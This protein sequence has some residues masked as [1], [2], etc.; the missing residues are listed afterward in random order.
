MARFGCGRDVGRR[1]RRRASCV[2][3]VR[4]HHR[5]SATCHHCNGVKVPWQ[6]S[7]DDLESWGRRLTSGLDSSA[8]LVDLFFRCALVIGWVCAGV[9]IYTVVDEV[10]FQLRHGMPSAR[11]R[12]LG[13]LGLLGRKLATV[14][15]AVLPIAISAVP[16]LAGP[17]IASATVGVVHERA[18]DLADPGATVVMLPASEMP[19]AA[20]SLGGAWVVDRGE[21]WRLDLGY[22]RA[23]R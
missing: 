16:T 10:V 11:H 4:R 7:I 6:W 2:A 20:S 13:G 17:S 1:C 12:R 18:A 5:G 19:M 14:L 3:A 22:R 21:T 15:V 23:R 9:V 8:A